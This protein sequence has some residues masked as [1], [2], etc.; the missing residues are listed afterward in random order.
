MIII[1]KAEKNDAVQLTALMDELISEPNDLAVVAT[2]IEEM[3]Q[4]ERYYL[5]VACDGETIAGSIMG[6]LC[7]DICKGGRPFLII[8]NVITKEDYRGSGV[9]RCLFDEVERWGR[10]HRCA[11]S[12]LVSGCK[13]TGAH[14][15]YE[16]IGYEKACGFRKYFD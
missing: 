16:R 10:E 14:A 4:D 9:G 12:A 7:R 2:E 11:Y 5:A 1:R 15:F 6:V 3:G 8:E 13:R